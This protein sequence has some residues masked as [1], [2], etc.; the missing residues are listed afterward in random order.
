M[1]EESYYTP[2]GEM[3]VDEEVYERLR[4]LGL[5]SDMGAHR[6]EHS[7]EVQIPFLQWL[8]EKAGR[9][10]GGG[11]RL[12]PI[13]MMAQDHG[14]ARKLGEM[15]R[16]ALEGR[17]ALVVASTDFSHYVPQ[18]VAEKADALAI[19]RILRLD[20]KGL[21]SLIRRT[22]IS[23]CGYGPVMA[24]LEA[25]EPSRAELLKYA[26]SGDISPMRDVVGYAAL[27]IY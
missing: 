11:M 6:Y 22:G 17:D 25:V 2:L 3:P 13:V 10:T 4:D 1:T 12:L 23:M 14:T 16:K 15:L 5:E 27:A 24:M 26:T 18:E 9:G 21:F 20:A 7:V 19:E 8:E